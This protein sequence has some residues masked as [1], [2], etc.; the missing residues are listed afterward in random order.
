MSKKFLLVSIMLMFM[1]L[2][3]LGQSATT[4][5]IKG[6]VTDA[7]GMEL[8]GI[9]ITLTSPSLVV[10][11][12]TVLSNESGMY[13]FIGLAPGI[14]MISYELKG[15]N[16]VERKGIK[17]S[18]GIATKID[19]KMSLKTLEEKITVIGQAPT[20]DTQT[21]TKS[22]TMD[23]NYL[24]LIPSLRS[25]DSY[26]NL[27]PGVTGGS[28]HGGS[29]RDTSYNLD[30]LNLSDPTS[31]EQGVFFG[32]DIM[33]EV[34]V[35]SGGLSAEYGG[36][37]GTTLNVVT[38]SGGNKLSG[39][40]SIYYRGEGLQSDNTEGTIL[41]GRK[42]GF[43]SEIEPGVTLGGPVIKDKLWFFGN[44]SYNKNETYVTGFPIDKDT[45]TLI[46]NEK[47]YPYIKFTFQPNQ[48]NKFTL[49][50]NYSNSTSDNFGAN[51]MSTEAHTTNYSTPTHVANLQW[52]RQFNSNIYMNV[53]VGGFLGRVDFEAKNSGPQI[54]DYADG[55]S[56]FDGTPGY[57]DLYKSNRYQFNIDTT[58]FVDNFA[59]SH[60]IKFGA[61]AM[62]AEVINQKVMTG[63]SDGNGFNLAWQNNLFGDPYIG[64]FIAPVDSQTDMF[65]S[66]LFVN[67]TWNV[68]KQLTIN[69]GVRLDYQVAIIPPQGTV[70]GKG[71]F[72]F[73]GYPDI[74]YD[75]TVSSSLT[76]LK[77]TNIS[78]RL[79][80]VYDLTGNGKTLIKGSFARYA[81]A[82]LS[83]YF[84]RLNPNGIMYYVGYLDENLNNVYTAGIEA[85]KPGV[86]GWKDH[87]LTAPYMDEL[88][89][90]IDKELFEDWSLSLRYIRKWDRNLV[91]DADINTLNIDKM[92]DT[93]ELEWTNYF[94][95]TTIDPYNG[96]TVTFYDII[97]PFL[98]NDV[99]LVNPPGAK[100]D[101]DSVEIILNKRYSN[102]WM[103]NASYVWAKSRGL[104]GTGAFGS[105]TVTYLYD[106][107]NFHINAEGRFP[108]E[109]RH[110]FKL[111]GVV[112]GPWGI[113][114]GGNFSYMS[115]GRY[116]RTI[117]NND[118]GFE[119]DAGYGDETIYA[120]SMG[121][122]GL[123]DL[124][125]IDLKI[126]KSIKLGAVNFRAFVDVFNLLNS[127]TEIGVN[128][129][130]SSSVLEYQAV[131][132]LQNPRIIRFGAKIEF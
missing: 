13:R 45:E 81:S 70:T 99:A 111:S 132:A 46:T 88:T 89:I 119:L 26:F 118:I 55:L 17:I 83:S 125:L 28:A 48:A 41:E 126:E 24:E 43:K 100:R 50:Y 73:A 94:P 112:R 53:K 130:S 113:N 2:I 20:V 65:S 36:T 67:D 59:G 35:S 104:I 120:E 3:C 128:E 52:M 122:Q 102:G 110:Q 30:G 72:G 129:R 51:N 61:E 107:P 31:G 6:V 79:S 29:V 27:T 60:E 131:T 9:L 96:E 7:D 115:G 32:M 38:K 33:E 93:G 15:M 66:G 114:L 92:M 57:S 124:M 58:V 14:Y 63:P 47:Y 22:T 105:S 19:M 56:T 82:N 39:T 5:A 21:T 44:M 68:N 40:A 78:P 23:K 64:I 106:N 37:R 75:R 84:F 123:P 8:P 42:S 11:K 80:F 101:Y 103:I 10:E 18:I 127:N 97:N 71:D 86:L 116:T 98:S 69:L 87:K 4:G 77:W 109:R 108:L 85:P 34:A 25:I 121:S 49:S 95:V 12:M 91:E 62:Y 16:T 76:D 74:T 117:N 90:G 1:S 54:Q